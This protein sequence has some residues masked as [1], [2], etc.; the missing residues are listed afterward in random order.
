MPIR[1]SAAG[2]K[3]SETWYKDQAGDTEELCRHGGELLPAAIL[4]TGGP[5]LFGELRV[6]SSDTFQSGASGL[7]LI[8]A[9]RKS[10]IDQEVEDEIKD[11]IA[12]AEASPFPEIGALYSNVFAGE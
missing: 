11:A 6:R 12:F 9:E 2:V 5:A 10:A 1:E 7:A 3:L 4:C 8:A